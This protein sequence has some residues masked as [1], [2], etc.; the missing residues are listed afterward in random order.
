M[1][2]TA[3]TTLA[4]YQAD[5]T[6]FQGRWG[7]AWALSVGASKDVTVERARQAVLAGAVT[8]APTDALPM[9]GADV[10]LPRYSVEGTED[11]RA[12][13][14]GAWDLWPWA[15]TASVL[16]TVAAQIGLAGP[17]LLTAR[18]WG[19]P[20]AATR[21]ARWW[22]LLGPQ[23]N[24]PIASDGAWGDPGTW[25]DGGTWDSDAPAA[26]IAD[27]RAAFRRFSNARDRG[28]VRFAFTDSTDYWGDGGVWDGTDPADVWTDAPSFLEVEI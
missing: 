23:P 12:R 24:V 15:G 2:P 3:P 11:Y 26:L 18:Q 21:W 22:M 20:D 4:A 28:F 10:A 7:R 25:G 14:L 6:P 13:I 17:V 5:L 16:L 19:L 9:L 27:L 1:P 8:R